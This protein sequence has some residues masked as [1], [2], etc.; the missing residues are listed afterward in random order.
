MHAAIKQEEIERERER[1]GKRGRGRR[2]QRG[3]RQDEL[4]IKPRHIGFSK[5]S[6]QFAKKP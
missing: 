4:A 3:L 6:K 5:K 1:D 2:E